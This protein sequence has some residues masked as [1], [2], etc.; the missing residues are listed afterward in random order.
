[1]PLPIHHDFRFL[2]NVAIRQKVRAICE[3]D[4][5]YADTLA[6]LGAVSNL[7]K[8]IGAIAPCL[9]KRYPKRGQ[10]ASVIAFFTVD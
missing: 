3:S 6:V 5:L 2:G 7:T 8:A 10:S 1:M 9:F 4:C